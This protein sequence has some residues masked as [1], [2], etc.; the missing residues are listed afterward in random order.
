MPVNMNKKLKMTNLDSVWALKY[1]PDVVRMLMLDSIR[2]VCVRDGEAKEA[3]P[4][5]FLAKTDLDQGK[6]I[7]A[8]F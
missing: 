2:D 4:P 7:Q 5:H 3:H 1:Q 6:K 8:H